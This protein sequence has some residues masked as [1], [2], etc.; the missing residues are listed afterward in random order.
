MTIISVMYLILFSIIVK[1]LDEGDK[2]LG[3]F[4]ITLGGIILCGCLFSFFCYLDLVPGMPQ[5]EIARTIYG[6]LSIGFLA[7]GGAGT[8]SGVVVVFIIR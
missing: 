3:I 4:F 8:A 7:G 6:W 2:G 1:A 5:T